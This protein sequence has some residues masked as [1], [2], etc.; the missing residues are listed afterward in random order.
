MKSDNKRKLKNYFVVRDLQIRLVAYGMIY[1]TV[2]VMITVA[3]V[4]SPT[5]REM[6][7]S[8]NLEVRY[9]AAQTF[10]ILTKWIIP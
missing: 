2:V 10:L 9:H 7:W 3:V 6:V 5:I 8:D 1:M 4:I